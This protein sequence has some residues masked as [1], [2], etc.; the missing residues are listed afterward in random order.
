VTE[1]SEPNASNGAWI[2]ANFT[3]VG[4]SIEYV[5]DVPADGL[6]Q[7]DVRYKENESRGRSQL[8]VDG[9]PLGP[10]ADH[11]QPRGM[12]K[13]IEFRE[14]RQGNLQLSKG[15]HTFAFTS[16]G[17]T[18][19]NYAVGVD[20]IKL[21]P[22]AALPRLTFEA[23]ET[24]TG[25]NSTVAATADPAA[26]K[27]QWHGLKATTVGDWAEY[28]VT[29][30]PGRY[31]LS[32]LVKAHAERGQAQLFVNGNQLGAGFDEYLAPA[33]GSYQY[34]EV[35]HGEVD[36]PAG[37]GVLRYVVTGRAAASTS[38]NLATDQILLAPVPRLSLAGKGN[39]R[40]GEQAAYTV[41]YSQFE[42]YYAQNRY[43]LWTVEQDHAVLTIDQ[44]G[45]ARAV[46]TGQAVLRVTSQLDPAVTTTLAVSVG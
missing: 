30:P 21:T 1:I 4:Q 15:G 27:G 3:A 37:S 14:R 43:L 28:T 19:G 11:F 23:E 10:E 17:K 18:G 9:N 12:Y 26:S 36:L 20:Y 16:T 29:V 40:L 34:R 6:Y 13:G 24:C 46:G 44:S 25:T 35:T 41:G 2:L 32:T 39:L 22:T 33:D 7:V 38:Y 31:R 8:R 42:P 45:V 5:V